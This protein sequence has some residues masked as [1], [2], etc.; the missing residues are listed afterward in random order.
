MMRALAI[1]LLSAA[2]VARS[3]DLIYFRDEAAMQNNQPFLGLFEVALYH[4]PD[5]PN[6]RA[7]VRSMDRA[8]TPH[9]WLN[10]YGLPLLTHGV[11]VP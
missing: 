6:L 9:S 3:D 1:L 7:V 4:W 10:Y 11:E 2:F 5:V 8:R